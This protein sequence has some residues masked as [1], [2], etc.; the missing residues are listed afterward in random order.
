MIIPAIDLMSGRC[1]RLVKGDFSQR[2][3][4]EVS[5]IAQ[6]SS[7]ASSSAEWV[8]IV[9]LDGAKSGNAEQSELICKIAKECAAKIQTGGGIRDIAQI[10]R[11][12]AGGVARIV[13]GSRAVTSPAQVKYWLSEF[14]ADRFTLAFDVNFD[15]GGTP[16]PAVKGWTE[17]SALSLWDCL[18][19]YASTGLSSILV[20]DIGRD[21]LLVG[22]NTDL[23]ADIMTKYPEYNLITSGGVGT[24][25]DVKALKALR[26]AGII[27]GKALY[28]NKFTLE[29]AIKC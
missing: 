23:Y 13:I 28:E 19:A 15:S 6:A 22:S 9:D 21:G 4:Y 10:E 14:G 25:D 26:P 8:H 3:Q 2:T 20:T 18:D 11:L 17:A 16:R 29:D 1:V 7:F 5:P 27:I 24:L 12:L